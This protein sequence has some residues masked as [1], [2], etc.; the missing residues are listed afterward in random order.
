[1]TAP[2][3]SRP[4]AGS[5]AA[6]WV[7]STYFSPSRLDW[8]SRAVAL[9]GSFTLPLSSTVTCACQEFGARFTSETRPTGTSLTRT[10]ALGTR[11]STSW[12]RT[13]TV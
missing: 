3:R 11:S 12:N 6:G 13:L 2:S 4:V 5:G 8:R 9:A 10:A 7:S 1:M